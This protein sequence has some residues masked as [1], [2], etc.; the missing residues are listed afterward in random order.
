M[1]YRLGLLDK[2]PLA[3]GDIAEDAL[4]RTVGFARRAEALGYH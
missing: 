4:A 1:T 2:S 3:S